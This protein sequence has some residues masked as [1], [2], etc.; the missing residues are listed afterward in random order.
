MLTRLGR[1]V[2]RHS[3]AVLIGVVLAFLGLGASGAGAQ[4]DLQL[5]RWNAPGTE[6]VRVADIL[7]EEFGTGNPNLALLVTA[8]DGDVDAPRTA[9]AARDLA[10][11]LAA[12]PDVTDVTSY[13]DG[14]ARPR[15]SARPSW[16][17]CRSPSSS[18]SPRRI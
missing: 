7:R 6:S 4:D 3:R 17:A 5:A 15:T 11:E 9:A 2:V 14:E 13:W 16:N 18:C 1:F 8:R 10:A 12:L